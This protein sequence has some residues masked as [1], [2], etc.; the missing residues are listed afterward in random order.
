MKRPTPERLILRDTIIRRADIRKTTSVT[1]RVSYLAV[2]I[3]MIFRRGW[4][5]ATMHIYLDSS[6]G[7]GSTIWANRAVG[8]RAVFIRAYLILLALSSPEDIF[9][10]LC[11]QKNPW[12]IWEPIHWPGQLVQQMCGPLWKVSR[13]NERTKAPPWMP[14]RSGIIRT[15]S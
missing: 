7:R 12:L 15:V 3:G 5:Y 6:C 10:S 13:N 9:A 11:G 1:Q 14:G 4:L 2:K 8:L